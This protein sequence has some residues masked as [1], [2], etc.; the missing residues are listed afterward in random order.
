MDLIYC[1]SS[2]KEN[3]MNQLMCNSLYDLRLWFPFCCSCPQISV[4]WDRSVGG[5][6]FLEWI[7]GCIYCRGNKTNEIW[8]RQMSPIEYYDWVDITIY[9]DDY[10][11]VYSDEST[12][13]YVL[14]SRHLYMSLLWNQWFTGL[15]GVRWLLEIMNWISGFQVNR[16]AMTK[17]LPVAKRWGSYLSPKFAI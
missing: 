13:L 12:F 16:C 3:G 2:S 15:I 11:T 4:L 10:N 6:R 1:R 7:A 17:I 14:R 9:S 5:P 8:W